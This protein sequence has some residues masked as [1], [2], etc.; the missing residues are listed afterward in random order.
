MKMIFP[1][2]GLNYRKRSIYDDLHKYRKYGASNHFVKHNGTQK[3]PDPVSKGCSGA[4]QPGKFLGD[5]V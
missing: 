1:N 3:R 4:F 5:F 2:S